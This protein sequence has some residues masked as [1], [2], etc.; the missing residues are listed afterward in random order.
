M[1]VSFKSQH[2]HIIYCSV[3]INCRPNQDFRR[4]LFDQMTIL[5]SVMIGVV[6][7]GSTRKGGL[8]CD[9]IHGIIGSG[10]SF[11]IIHGIIGSG[12]S[13][14]IIHEIIGSGLSFDIIH[15]IIGSGL[16]FDIIHGI[17]GSGLSFNIIHGI[18]GSGLS[19]DII[20]GIIGSGVSFD[21]VHGILGSGL[22]LAVIHVKHFTCFLL[23]LFFLNTW[24]N[25]AKPLYVQPLLA[26]VWPLELQNA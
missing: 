14:D 7:I 10:L 25:G 8:S 3:I 15:G 19:F 5:I 26:T 18:I 23:I 21:I 9:I 6:N 17:I 12:L 2:N 11:D 1:T 16:S 24:D 13:F 20:Y 22:S 4:A